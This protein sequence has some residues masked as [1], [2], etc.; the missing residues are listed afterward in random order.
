MARMNTRLDRL[1]DLAEAK[2]IKA[3]AQATGGKPDLRLVVTEPGDA[4][5]GYDAE[6][7]R[8]V[9]DAEGAKAVLDF[10]RE[11]GSTIPEAID[12]EHE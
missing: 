8:L 11:I 4:E 5:P 10:H 2:I 9:L 6:R 1:E 3:Q 7:G 12:H